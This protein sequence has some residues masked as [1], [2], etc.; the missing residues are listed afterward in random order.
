MNQ[1][2]THRSAAAVH[3]ERLE[4]LGDAILGMLVA[5]ELYARNPE[6]SEGQLTRLRSHLVREETLADLA[7]ENKLGDRLILGPG[8]L[9]SADWRRD[10]ILADA[11]EAV[12]AAIYLDAGLDA[13]RA[14]V[15][16]LYEARWDQL[17]DADALKDP[18][19]R[20]QEW[21][22]GHAG[23]GLPEYALVDESG[24]AHKRNFKV[25]GT[26]IVPGG[27]AAKTVFAQGRSRRRAEQDTARELLAWLHK[28]YGQ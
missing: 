1:A 26:L 17:P 27:D 23:W 2:L 20:L 4:F 7:R 16:H 11:V 12:L 6:A 3:N 24:P 15:Q 8:E 10:S 19:T 5:S 13:A 14:A 21:T 22:Q 28:E 9:S 18:K 25:S